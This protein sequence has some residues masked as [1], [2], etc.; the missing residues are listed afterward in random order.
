VSIAVGTRRPLESRDLFRF[1]LIA[2]PQL[3]PDGASL[4][5]VRTT[6]DAD[7]NRARS[8]IV[9]TDIASGAARVL[10]PASMSASHPR[11]SPDGRFVLFLAASPANPV[12]DNSG[13]ASATATAPPMA[14]AVAAGG[15][16][17]FVVAASGGEPWQMTSL[18]GGARD[19]AWS[20]DGQRVAF[21]TYVDPDHGIETLDA[22]TPSDDPYARFNR[23]VLVSTRARWRM[24]GVGAFGPYRK[25]VAMIAFDEAHFTSDADAAGPLPAVVLLTH[26]AFDLNA[27]VWSPDGRTI[28]AAGN[29]R[30]GSDSDR[31]QYVYLIDVPV[32]SDSEVA[33]GGSSD[34][35]APREIF[36]LEEMRSTDL[37]WSP[38]GAT[39]AV[40]GHDGATGH[41]GN[42]RVWL[43]DVATRTGRCITSHLD[44]TFADA[45]GGDL[46]GGGGQSGPRWS[47]DGRSL[48]LL[49]SDR[50]RVHLRRLGIDGALEPEPVLGG[51]RVVFAFTTD[52]AQRTVAAL[53]ADAQT[54]PE[55]VRVDLAS[56]GVP[57]RALTAE[58][59]DLLAELDLGSVTHFTF[60]AIGGAAAGSTVDAWLV[61]PPRR[62]VN[63]RVPVI[64]YTGGGPGGMRGFEFVFEYQFH[65]AC[66]R[67]VLYVNARGCQGSGEAFCA[68]ILGDWGSADARDNLDG[69][70]AA[71]A[72]FEF[73]DAERKAIAGGSYGGYLVNWILG[74]RDDFRAAIADRSI[75]NRT[76]TWGTSDIGHLREFEFGGGPPWE[77]MDDYLRQSP[78]RF[79]ANVRTP[80]LVVHAGEDY[81]TPIEQGEQLYQSLVW[82]GVP[83]RFIY[84][85]KE[86]HDL[87][88]GGQPW[89]RVLRLEKYREWWE[90]WV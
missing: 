65:A 20:P 6:L 68:S 85:P 69:L 63:E 45:A 9:I 75:S 62:G 80:T 74:H 11:W 56:P 22:L 25:H 3:S 16:Q 66:G 5:W 71:L 50:G 32:H 36:G 70:D 7:A 59:A 61:A 77:T 73:L 90:R 33:P 14:V 35:A 87:S 8:E 89:H 42:Q 4:A 52:A 57:P 12:S 84:F 17:L 27:P 53:V 26:G 86:N 67:A 39:I 76:A 1:R 13:G 21:L 72:R 10:T 43:V 54:P 88:R 79:V 24:N 2:D 15:P 82:R 47:S 55:I 49:A 44:V 34:L 30:P 40:G 19:A 64:L 83:A 38:D 28:A 29:I 18:R 60:P 51:D 46:R 41:Y 78:I 48:L 23:D 37:A 31:R 81:R 58:N